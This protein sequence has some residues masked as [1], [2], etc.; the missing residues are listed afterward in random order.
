MKTEKSIFIVWKEYQRRVDVIVP[1][2]ETEHIY[3]YY[4]WEMKSKFFKAISYIPKTMG[5]LKCLFRNKPSLVF[6]Q[7]P[8]TPALYA[9]A[10]YSWLTGARYVADCHIGLTNQRW[11]NWIFVKKILAKGLMIVHNA[12]LI[13]QV[14]ESVKITP[15]VLRDGI[16][17]KQI[18]TTGAQTLLEKFGLSSKKY[19]LFPSSFDKD[20]PVE[21]VFEAARLL[22]EINF[23]MTWHAE[24]LSKEMREA[25]PKNLVL[26]GFL[27]INDFNQIFANAGVA[28]V[29]TTNEGVQ[30]S[31]MQE[32]M[33]FEIPSVVTGLK[34]TRFLY[35]DAPIYIENTAESI[36]E[37]IRNAFKNEKELEEKIKELR[38]ES[39]KEFDEQIANLKSILGLDMG[40]IVS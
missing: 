6:V 15:F 12:H 40:D 1:Y 25:V 24:K 13:Q 33:A 10:L 28:L 31:G 23:V 3:F 16:A 30:L 20:E 29:L 8:P 18:D 4:P 37:G 9:V 21:E 17:K 22:P 11:L 14:E 7:F 5:T 26:T 27:A 19:V 36:A 39:E 34:T 35:K 2:L 32:A 38:I